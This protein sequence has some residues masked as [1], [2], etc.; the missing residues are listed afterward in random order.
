MKSLLNTRG[1]IR[2]DKPKMILFDYG[3]TL[4]YEGKFDGIAGTKAV[5]RNC[6]ENP[7]CVTAEEIQTFANELNKDIGRYNPETQ[8]LALIEVHNHPFQKYLYD[9]FGIKILVSPL[10]LETVFW[11]SAA[12]ARPTDGI[13]ELLCCL[14]DR[15]IRTGVISNIGFSGLAVTNRINKLLPDNNFEF[16]VTSSEYVFRKPS[17][18]IFEI[19]LKKSELEA[20]DVW[21]CGDNVKCDIEGA[22]NCSITPIWYKGAINTKSACLPNVCIEINEWIELTKIL[23]NL[24]EESR[25]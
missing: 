1:G 22:Y 19:A 2:L 18:R 7:L 21:Y 16:I 10:E 11:D 14:K 20:E 17:R 5:L 9:Y 23:L 13:N 3:Q 12:P 4:M 25:Y 24:Q 8:H 6:A 15:N